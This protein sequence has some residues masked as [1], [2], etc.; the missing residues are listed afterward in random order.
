L[1]H[2]WA[3]TFERT[4]I[5]VVITLIF[6]AL[7][8]AVR[9]VNRSGALAGTI[10]CFLLFASAGPGTFAVLITLFLI[11]WLATRFRAR[12]KQQLGVAE[13]RQGR[14]AWQVLANLGV[15]AIGAVCA[16]ATGDTRWI[17]AMAAALAESATDTVASEI[18]QTAAPRSVLITTWKPVPSGTDGGIT[19]SGSL[20]G[21]VAG[22]VLSVTAVS[23]GVLPLRVLWIPFVAG[24]IG[25]FAD[26]F[27]QRRDWI[28][29]NEVNLLGTL[30]SAAIGFAL[31]H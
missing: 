2:G 26:S 27:I 20:A 19:F 9:G 21:T 18:G 15:A 29:N 11:T 1:Q 25:M 17:L 4:T 16:A 8:L 6:A 30:V 12:R 31:S 5:A 10:V 14:N 13:R 23:T 3:T 22:L 24:V 28:N 7:A